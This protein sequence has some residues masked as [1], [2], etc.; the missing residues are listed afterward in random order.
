M[1]TTYDLP[2]SLVKEVKLRAVREGRKLKDTAAEII[3]RGL[4]A[5]EEEQPLKKARIG[6]DK[7]TG[8]PVILGGRKAAPGTELTP[9]RVAEILLRQEVEWANVAGR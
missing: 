9:D 1:K 6:K 4:A 3:R 5:K 7:L 2:E 8:L